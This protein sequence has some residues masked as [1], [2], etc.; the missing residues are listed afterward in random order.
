[1]QAYS[2]DLRSRVMGD[3]A[4]GMTPRQAAEKYKVGVAWVRKLVRWQKQTGS[5][6]QR[7]QRVSRASKLDPHVERLKQ[8]VERKPDATLKE[9]R[10]ELGVDA[11]LATLS[12]RLARLR[13]TVK[14]NAAGDRKG[15]SGRGATAT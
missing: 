6:A 2:W 10:E 7:V 13:L 8:A 9:L 14:K 4:L 15:S 11:G 3:V 5:F 12:R 1:M